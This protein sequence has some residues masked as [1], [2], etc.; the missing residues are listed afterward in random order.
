MIGIRCKFD[1]LR[2]SI[3]TDHLLNNICGGNQTVHQW[4]F[5]WF[6]QMV[7]KPRERTGT[8][9]VLRGKQG[10][11]KTIIGEVMGLLIPS[12]YFLVDDPRY[13]TGNFNL[14]MATCLFLQADEAVWG[15]DKA[16]EGRLKGLI[17]APMQMIEAKGVDAIRLANFV[18]V[19]L[20]SNED[21]VIP[22]GAEERRFQVLD[23]G[24]RCV[25]NHDYFRE[26]YA[27]LRDG[28]LAHLLGALLT[29]DLSTV[30]LRQIIRTDA[31][32]D[33]KMRSFDPI[34][35]WLFNC[36]SQG[37]IPRGAADWPIEV[38][39][40]LLY[41]DYINQS[42]KQGIR[43]KQDA[44]NFGHKLNKLMPG[45]TETRPHL[46]VTGDHGVTTTRR[47]WCYRLPP[48]FQVRKFWEDKLGQTINWEA[49][50]DPESVEGEV[51]EFSM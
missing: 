47:T 51:E 31:L 1:P 9:L 28:G 20:T 15:G 14:H 45:I 6:A 26:L 50:L 40:A 49:P 8:S 24:D 44:A 12:H 22:A 10:A 39:K 18:R 36:L 41:D 19:M 21:W 34:E 25:Q 30:N 11:G 27:Q 33:Q 5:G 37:A 32:L 4:V 48:L 16:V 7:Q 29:F 2:F 17:T 23:V 43:R 38:P 35:S 13:V 42:E 3:F 46:P